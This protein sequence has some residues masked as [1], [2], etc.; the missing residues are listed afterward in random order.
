MI[1]IQSS[2][3]PIDEIGIEMHHGLHRCMLGQMGTARNYARPTSLMMD[4]SGMIICMRI[5]PVVR[6]GY[7]TCDSHKAKERYK[8]SV[9]DHY[10]L[11]DCAT[12]CTYGDSEKWDS[13]CKRI[14]KKNLLIFILLKQV[15]LMRFHSVFQSRHIFALSFYK[16]TSL[17]ISAVWHPVS[18]LYVHVF[19]SDTPV[20]YHFTVRLN[21]GHCKRHTIWQKG[22]HYCVAIPEMSRIPLLWEKATI[23]KRLLKSRACVYREGLHV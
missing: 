4:H 8:K 12:V 18:T 2:V 7:A 11:A 9:C 10:P 5:H 1:R 14:K 13:N 19:F 20:D 23:L 6:H 17:R 21:W 15:R 22:L 16:K 3:F